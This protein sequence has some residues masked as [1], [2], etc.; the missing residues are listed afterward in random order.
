MGIVRSL[1]AIAVILS[2]VTLC[3]HTTPAEAIEFEFGFTEGTSDAVIDGFNQAGDLWSSILVDD[4]TVNLDVQFGALNSPS[5]G[6]FS[7]VRVNVGYR[8]FVRALDG[9]ATSINDP[10]AVQN[11]PKS[12]NFDLLVDAE[13]S[14]LI[15]GT[16]NNPNGAGSSVPYLD[17][18]GDCNNRSIRITRANAKALGLPSTGTQNCA[19]SAFNTSTTLSDGTVQL[20]SLFAWDFDRSDGVDSGKFDFVGVAAQGIGTALGFISGVDVLDFNSPLTTS[21]GSFFFNDSQFPFVSSVDLFRFSAD[22]VAASEETQAVSVID[23]T[24]GRTV[25]NGQEVDKYFSI[26][27]GQTK[28]ASFSTGVRTGDGQRASSWKADEIT[29]NTVGILEPTPAPGQKLGITA[30]DRLLFD[31][32]GYD[33]AV[34]QPS[35]GDGGND[36]GGFGGGSDGGEFPEEPV[37][38]PEPTSGLLL[39]LGFAIA[40]KYRQKRQSR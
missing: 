19:P 39:G 33:I 14:L 4:I 12:A 37:S 26:D 34:N 1:K 7:P 28:I 16:R 3:G 29:G 24:T 30:T 6:R 23:W 38:V 22:S 2:T 21:E 36:N 17:A 27:G 32:I 10:I 15:N 40:L 35:G 13:L 8:N 20:N 31:V 25:S 9:D 5:L 11:L 18:D